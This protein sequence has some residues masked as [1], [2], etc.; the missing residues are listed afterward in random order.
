MLAGQPQP[1]K[2]RKGQLTLLTLLVLLAFCHEDLHL[3]GRLERVSVNSQCRIPR[4][5]LCLGAPH[6][7][8]RATVRRPRIQYPGASYRVMNRG[9]RREPIFND[10]QD[11]VLFLDTLAEA[12]EK[13]DWEIH[14]WCLMGNHFHLVTETPRG[15]LVNGIVMFS[16]PKRSSDINLGPEQVSVLTIDTSAGDGYSKNMARRLRI[17]YPGCDVSRDESR[18][19]AR[20]HLPG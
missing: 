16:R 12:C 7:H 9:D 19:P 18:R 6:H 4:L 2:E 11:R 10:D 17:Q 20:G 15:N 13:T 5:T 8:P 14:A 3:P 1:V